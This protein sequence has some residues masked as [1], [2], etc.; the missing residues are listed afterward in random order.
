MLWLPFQYRCYQLRRQGQNAAMDYTL[1]EIRGYLGI[2]GEDRLAEIRGEPSLV[3]ESNIHDCPGHGSFQVRLDSKR[4]ELMEKNRSRDMG[5]RLQV[6]AIGFVKT[7]NTIV[8]IDKFHTNGPVDLKVPQSTWVANV[9]SKWKW[10][11]THI[12][13]IQTEASETDIVTPKAIEHLRAAEG[14]FLQHN[15]RETMA[16][17]Y[18]AFEAV[19]LQRGRQG[20]D[21][22]FFDDL[23][24]NLPSGMRTKYKDLFRSYCVMLHLGRHESG[25]EDA[26]QTSV[27][28]RDAQLALILGQAIL[29][30]ISGLD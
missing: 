18:S 2:H 30:Y 15:P 25:Q 22:E 1:P 28:H 23:L 24:S 8:D 19:A 5:L 20:P 10:A 7:E 29:S 26:E 12:I 14:H 13:E 4:I 21:K 11:Q 3:I 27:Q 6:W 16:S 9:L 17:L